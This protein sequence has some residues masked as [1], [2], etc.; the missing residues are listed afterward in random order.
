VKSKSKSP[1]AFRRSVSENIIKLVWFSFNKYKSTSTYLN[2]SKYFF[3]PAKGFAKSK[4]KAT[5]NP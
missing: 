1:L 5:T 4:D 3:Y 2:K